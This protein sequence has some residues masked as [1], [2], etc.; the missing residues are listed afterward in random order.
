MSIA[1][2]RPTHRLSKRRMRW[3]LNARKGATNRG[4]AP[5]T[6]TLDDFTGMRSKL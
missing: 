2:S 6:L 3:K 4:H 5:R 1:H